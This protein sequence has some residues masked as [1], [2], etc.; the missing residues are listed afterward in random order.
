VY[1]LYFKQIDSVLLKKTRIIDSIYIFRKFIHRKK[2]KN[3]DK[4]KNIK[5]WKI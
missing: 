4:F 3:L 1:L 5:K 2:G